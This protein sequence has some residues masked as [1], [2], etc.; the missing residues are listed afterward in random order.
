MV[1]DKETTLHLKE[2]EHLSHL[3]QS[4]GWT[5]ASQMLKQKEE[6][7][8]DLSLIP[9]DLTVEQ[10]GFEAKARVFA[11]S[12]IREWRREMDVKI[13]NYQSFLAQTVQPVAESLVINRE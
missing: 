5:V 2:G 6:E 10:F 9:E 1:R 13:E 11:L 4:D 8:A 3:I 7:L 12:L